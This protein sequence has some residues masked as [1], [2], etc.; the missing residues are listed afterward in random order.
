MNREEEIQKIAH[1]LAKKAFPDE[2]NIWAR[3]NIEAKKT[4]S[5]CIAIAKWAD[6]SMIDK[7]V[8]QLNHMLRN[9]CFVNNDVGEREIQAIIEYFREAMEE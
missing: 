9:G 1:E 2:Y 5:C 6:K 8:A 7:A 4:E 3:E